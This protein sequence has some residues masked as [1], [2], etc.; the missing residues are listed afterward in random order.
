MRILRA[1]DLLELFNDK[2]FQK[3]FVESE[4]AVD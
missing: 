1:I 3:Q 4:Q 2:D